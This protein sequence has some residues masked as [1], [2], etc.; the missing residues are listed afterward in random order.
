MEQMKITRQKIM[1]FL[2]IFFLVLSFDATAQNKYLSFTDGVKESKNENTLP[3][4]ETKNLKTK[5]YEVSFQF[6]GAYIADKKL[7]KWDK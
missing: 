1:T 6:S 4:R 2:L 7:Q 5:G 3:S